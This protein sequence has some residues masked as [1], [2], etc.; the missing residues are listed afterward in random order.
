MHL[1]VYK[2]LAGKIHP[3]VLVGRRLGSG[4]GLYMLLCC[5]I[6]FYKSIFRHYLCKSF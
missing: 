1:P 2:Y 3:N 6:F 5:L 4:G